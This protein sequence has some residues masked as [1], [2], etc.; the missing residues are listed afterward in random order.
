MM[1]RKRKDTD[2]E[3]AKNMQGLPKRKRNRRSRLT[4]DFTAD[5]TQCI[6]EAG[7]ASSKEPITK[8][9]SKKPNKDITEEECALILLGM[10]DFKLRSIREKKIKLKQQQQRLILLRHVS[11]CE[12]GTLCPISKKCAEWKELWKHIVKCK[13]I[14]CE[15]KYCIS[16]R[17]ILT[18]Y[19]RCKD[20]KCKV[21]APVR[22][23]IDVNNK[24]S[25][26]L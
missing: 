26:R 2:E 3:I 15:T 20:K 1:T 19:Y 18:H 13:N 4:L 25:L 14:N 21:C 7:G 6:K 17:Y 12:A 22:A 5:S 9:S 23:A 8:A 10:D 16:S 24:K 11:M